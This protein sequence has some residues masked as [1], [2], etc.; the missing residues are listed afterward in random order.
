MGLYISLYLLSRD[1][2]L[3]HYLGR[4]ANHHD[5]VFGV[6]FGPDGDDSALRLYMADGSEVVVKLTTNYSEE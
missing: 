4:H 2:Y 3:A 6:T 5:D 1:N